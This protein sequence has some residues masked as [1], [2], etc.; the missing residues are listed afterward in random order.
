MGKMV[1]RMYPISDIH[2]VLCDTEHLRERHYYDTNVL[3]YMCS[4]VYS[5]FQVI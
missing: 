4:L 5:V 1:H 3:G 2:N